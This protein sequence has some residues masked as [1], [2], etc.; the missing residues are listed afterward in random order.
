MLL[1]SNCCNGQLQLSRRENRIH[2]RSLYMGCVVCTLWP[3][4]AAYISP[5]NHPPHIYLKI[6]ISIPL[7]V[8][9]WLN[10]QYP[11]S[12]IFWSIHLFIYSF[13]P[14]Q[15]SESFFN[16]LP[17]WL[18]CYVEVNTLQVPQSYIRNKLWKE[19][20][21]ATP[22]TLTNCNMNIKINSKE[23]IGIKSSLERITTRF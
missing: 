19:M 15:I 17:N 7:Q 16:I 9:P 3:Q 14:L 22:D 11:K 12:P 18:Q 2:L 21:E 6:S 23:R 1:T 4:A 10:P 8:L 20:L 5:Q 13:I